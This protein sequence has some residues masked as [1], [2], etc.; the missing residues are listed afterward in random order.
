VWVA[1]FTKAL[2]R[3]LEDELPALLLQVEPWKTER[4]HRLLAKSC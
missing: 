4:G 1:T 3:Q 2:Q